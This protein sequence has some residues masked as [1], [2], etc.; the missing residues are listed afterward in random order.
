MTLSKVIGSSRAVSRKTGSTAKVIAVITPRAPSPSRAAANTSGFSSAEHRS[1]VP[2]AVTS[3]RPRIC[4]DMDAES[5][6]VPWVPVEVA[7]ATVCSMMSPMFVSDRPSRARAALSRLSGVPASTVTV[8][9]VRSTSRIPVSSSGRISTPSV[10]AAAVNECP[11][12]TGFT[13]RPSSRALRRASASSSTEAGDTARTGR[14]VTLPAQLR[15][16][17]AVVRA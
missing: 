8:I 16:V 14:A 9:A 3:S 10:A 11:V 7:P 4:A 13:R 12:P 1:T 15:H 5:R 6:P 17:L 2:L